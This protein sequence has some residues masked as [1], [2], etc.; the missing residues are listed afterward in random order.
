M[1]NFKKLNI[2][3]IEPFFTGSHK[4]WAEGYQ[5]SS[6]H[7]L[8]IISLKGIYWKWRMHGGAI[9]LARIFNQHLKKNGYPDLIMVTDMLNLPVFESFAN[10]ADLPIISF[11]HENSSVTPSAT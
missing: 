3:L 9:T 1:E 6:K 4:S 11:F 2:V 10:I 5:K 7:N 8:S